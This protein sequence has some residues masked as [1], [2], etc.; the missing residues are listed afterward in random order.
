MAIIMQNHGV[1]TIGN[2][3]WQATKMAVEVEDIAKITHM[4]MLRGKPIILSSE[5]I[6]EVHY[7]YENLYGQR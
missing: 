2:S 3:A 1:F 6:E 7:L 4:A 5:Q